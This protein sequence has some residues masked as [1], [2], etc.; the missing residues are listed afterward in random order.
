MTSLSGFGQIEM[1]GLAR[2]IT[3]WTIRIWPIRF[4]PIDRAFYYHTLVQVPHQWPGTIDLVLFSFNGIDK[5]RQKVVVI[6]DVQV[7][8]PRLDDLHVAGIFGQA[9]VED[10]SSRVRVEGDQVRRFGLDAMGTPGLGLYKSDEKKDSKPYH[11][12]S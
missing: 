11:H 5:G 12:Q 3:S 8:E 1:D 6:G 2:L 7:K 10:V 9:V 4:T